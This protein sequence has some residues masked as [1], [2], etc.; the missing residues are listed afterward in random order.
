MAK[1]F[2]VSTSTHPNTFAIVDDDDYYAIIVGKK[3]FA[4]QTG[5]NPKT[6]YV[7]SKVN[8]KRVILHRLLAGASNRFEIVDHIN[9]NGLDNRRSNL[10]ICSQ[11]ENLRNRGINRNNTSGYKGVSWENHAKKWLVKIGVD[12]KKILIGRFD[13][14]EDAAIAYKIAAIKF[15]GQFAQFTRVEG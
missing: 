2:D 3:W 9:G 7:A 5:R 15:H 13:N 10:R 4:Y 6:I 11:R 12:G 14:K 8:G 1:S